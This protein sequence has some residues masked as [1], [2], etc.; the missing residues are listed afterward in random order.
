MLILALTFAINFAKLAKPIRV[1]DPGARLASPDLCSFGYP[2]G[3]LPSSSGRGKDFEPM[4]RKRPLFLDKPIVME[5]SA[6]MWPTR[7]RGI[8]GLVGDWAARHEADPSFP[9]PRTRSSL[10]AW[11]N[12]GAPPETD[13]ILALAAML[14]TD[15]LAIFDFERNGYFKDFSW[16]RQQIY[17][18]IAGGRFQ[19]ILD[20][21]APRPH[22][23][24][25]GLAK[26]FYKR[27]WFAKEFEHK[28]DGAI[29]Q[30]ADIHI[31]FAG[32]TRFAPRCVHI[33]YRRA[34]SRDRIWRYYGTIRQFKGRTRL[35]SE[36]GAHFEYSG[37]D[38]PENGFVFKTYFGATH[39]E[40]RVASLHEFSCQVTYPS[41]SKSE[42]LFEADP[43]R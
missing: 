2:H 41:T 39:V 1:V 29:N 30:Y 6:I 28:A 22:W 38:Q 37:A 21:M 42:L 40:F 33:A 9:K 3:D 8:D 26:K 12:D 16:L 43:R 31:A 5:L 35:F 14:D 36:S 32:S 15:P 20:L 18:H 13:A 7:P 10:Y 11:L 19:A 34:D 17:Y 4:S 25:D 24:N 23:P 27:P